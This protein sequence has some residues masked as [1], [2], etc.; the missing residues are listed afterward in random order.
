MVMLEETAYISK[1]FA[2]N[3]TFNSIFHRHSEVALSVVSV[4]TFWVSY[5]E[6]TCSSGCQLCANSARWNC[7]LKCDRPQKWPG[8]DYVTEAQW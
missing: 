5:I 7:P 3:K 8:F 4:L 6:Q 1:T 2:Q